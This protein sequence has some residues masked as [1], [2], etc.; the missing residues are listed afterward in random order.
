[1][2]IRIMASW[3]GIRTIVKLGDIQSC[4]LCRPVPWTLTKEV[5]R[6]KIELQRVYSVVDSHYFD[7]EQDPVPDLHRSKK[8]NS[9]PHYI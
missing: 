2:W 9:V 6:L 5:L 4:I 3:I 7:E 8:S 1:M